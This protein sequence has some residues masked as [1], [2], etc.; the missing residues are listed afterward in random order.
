MSMQDPVADMLTRIRN[1]QERDKPDVDMPSSRLKV[2]LTELLK[3]EG[4]VEDYTVSK[5]KKPELTIRLKYFKGKKVIEWL[6][7]VSKPGLRIYEKCKDLPKVWGGL[8]VA[9]IST[10]KGL[11]SDRA[12]RK[13]G[14]GGEVICYVA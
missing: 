10:P 14:I 13:A 1:A 6:K 12:A 7:R 8:G 4:Y 2:S 5:G 3:Q 9:V 11:M